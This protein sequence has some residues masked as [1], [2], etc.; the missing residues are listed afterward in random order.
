MNKQFL[1]YAIGCGLVGLL[2][3]GI[4]LGNFLHHLRYP[5]TFTLDKIVHDR[6]ERFSNSNCPADLLQQK[7]SYLGH[8]TQMI[9]FEG[10]DKKTVLKLFLQKSIKGEKKFR[11]KSLKDRVPF[12]R[13]KKEKKKQLH[14]EESL[15]STFQHYAKAFEALKEETGLIGIHLSATRG[16]YS[17]CYIRDFH[18]KEW[19]CDLD[20]ISFVLQAKALPVRDVFPGLQTEE[21]KRNFFQAM[22]TLLDQRARKGFKDLGQGRVFDANYGFIGD[23]AILLDAGRLGYSEEVRLHP[24]PEIKKMQGRLRARFKEKKL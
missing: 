4:W 12:W 13:R 21:E 22:D 23:R 3:G 24:E 18:G 19:V 11:I 8:G 6:V 14:R 15:Q 20:R 7:F 1:R 5:D 9:A 10:E 2:V 17:P 16:E